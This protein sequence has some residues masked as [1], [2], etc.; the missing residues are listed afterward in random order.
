VVM[1]SSSPLMTLSVRRTRFT[2]SM[3]VDIFPHDRIH[4]LRKERG[5]HRAAPNFCCFMVG[6]Y[7][8]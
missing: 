7:L 3:N 5:R 8:S 6:V 4:A 2:A 1:L